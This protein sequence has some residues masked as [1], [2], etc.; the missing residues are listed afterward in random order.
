MLLTAC[1]NSGRNSN[2]QDLSNPAPTPAV[3]N[4]IAPA[5]APDAARGAKLYEEKCA[6]CHG[7]NGDGAGPQAAAI[8]AQGQTVANLIDPNKTRATKPSDWFQI[9][10]NGRLQN[11][12]PPFSGSLNP[13][14]RWDV[15]AYTWALGTRPD[16]LSSGKAV[17]E[18]NCAQCHSAANLGKPDLLARSA[19]NDILAAMGRGDQH[20]PNTQLSEIQR[21]QAANYVRSLA[22]RYADPVAIRDATLKGAGVLS[23][24]VENK[25]AGGTVPANVPVVLHVYDANSEVFTRSTTLDA[26]G[27]VKFDQLPVRRD[28]FYEPEMIYNGARFFGAPAQITGTALAPR[29]FVIYE[30]SNDAGQI[31]ISDFHYFVQG[32]DE[33]KL[34]IAE[35]YSID[36]TGDRAYI[37]KPMQSLR[38]SLPPD[39]TNIRFDGPGIGARFIRDGDILIDMDAVTPG[40]P[41]SGL[42]LIYEIP[43]R[44]RKTIEREMFYPVKKWDVVMPGLALRAS[45]GGLVDRGQQQVQNTSFNLF[46]AEQGM[47]KAGPL[48]FEISGQLRA[49]PA[50]GS[51]NL[52]IG[53]GVGLFVLSL[54]MLYLSVLRGR[55]LRAGVG[56]AANDKVMRQALLQAVADLDDEFEAGK[57]NEADYCNQRD[58]LMSRLLAAKNRK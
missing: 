46:A 9:I 37:A 49:G 57:L 10:T 58:A 23:W 36:N 50:P 30:V 17:F 35:V 55:A 42:T 32:A 1:S 11:L 27:V 15:I 14:D 54:G 41:A 21:G 38:F 18:A 4:A 31:S 24:Q 53:V 39:A 47:P 5:A 48:R 26:N 44:N 45:G 43:Y 34:S 6:A 28:Y 7:T 3:Q 19:L 33:G 2:N 16:A 8:R 13:Q 20:R 12:M 25:S 52:S 22:Y 56:A 40:K 51:D 29:P